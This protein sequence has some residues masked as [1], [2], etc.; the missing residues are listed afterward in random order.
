MWYAYRG[1]HYRIGYAHSRDGIRWKRRDDLVGLE[2]SPTGWDSLA[3]A[4]PH[5]FVHEDHLY[6]IYNGNHYGKEGLG[7]A[8]RP[9]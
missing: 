6:M 2:L 7:L 1:E 4:Y 5:V 3:Q 9:L 8:K